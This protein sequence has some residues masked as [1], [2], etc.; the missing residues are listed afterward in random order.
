MRDRPPKLARR[1]AEQLDLAARRL[2]EPERQPQQRRLAASIRPGDRD[3]LT[4]VDPQVDAGQHRRPLRV[5]EVDVLEL[6]G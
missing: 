1:F 2:L 6:D 3:E 5:R 4:G